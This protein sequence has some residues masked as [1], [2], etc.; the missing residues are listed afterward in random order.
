MVF[1]S[2]RRRFLALTGLLVSAAV[3]RPARADD[4]LDYGPWHIVSK[5]NVSRITLI[6]DKV[7][8]MSATDADG[9]T[10]SGNISLR[11]SSAT[12]DVGFIGTFVL[13]YDNP[14]AKNSPDMHFVTTK[15]P[16]TGEFKT[17]LA[18]QDPAAVAPATIYMDGQKITT[19]TLSGTNSQI[20]NALFGP[21]LASLVSAKNVKVILDL[22]TGPLTI[23]DIN[24]K[25][26]AGMLAAA[27]KAP[28]VNYQRFGD[29]GSPRI[30]QPSGKSK[31]CFLTTAC[32]E[33]I[34]LPHDCAELTV[35]RRFRDVVMMRTAEGR[36]DV[37][38]YYA[39][40]PLILSAIRSRSEERVL[41]RL[42]VT[43]I[44]PSVAAASLGLHRLT[45]RIYTAMMTKLSRRYLAEPAA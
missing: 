5:G 30:V 9:R 40:A 33:L 23:F 15:D 3:V 37:A 41:L 27:R 16:K 34:G 25:D 8:V 2:T 24:L 45:R 42:Y 31:D 14:N 43:H 29:A 22:P 17:V 26:T 35:L 32:C 39:E 44:L 12:S 7:K 11:Y 1:L 6:P 18:G 13:T 19:L 36:A 20:L 10:G 28:D 4:E 38:R 21:K